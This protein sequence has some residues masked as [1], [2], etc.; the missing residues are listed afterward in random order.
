MSVWGRNVFNERHDKRV[1][2]FGNEDP[3]YT[4]ARYE[5]RADP[6]QIGVTANFRF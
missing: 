1:F 6:R 5:D 2:F 4:P 3:D